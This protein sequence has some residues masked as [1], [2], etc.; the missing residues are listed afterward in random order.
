MRAAYI[1]HYAD[2]LGANRSLLELVKG[3]REGHG[4]TPLVMAPREGDLTIALREADIPVQVFP[5]EPWMTERWY[6]GGPHHR[7]MQYWRE[8]KAAR[9]RLRTNRQLLPAMV[10][11]LRA[12]GVQLVH[13]NSAVAGI[14]PMVAAQAGV[15]LVWHVREMPEQHYGMHLDAGRRGYGD[16]LTKADRVIAISHAVEADVRRYAPKARV[17]VVYNGVLAAH[18]FAELAVRTGERWAVDAPF[19]F[20]MVGLIHPGKHQVEAVE[21]LR[22]LLDRGIEARLVIVGAGREAPVRERIAQLGLSAHVELTGYLAEP[23]DVLFRSHAL[24]MCSRNEA[25]G[26]AT[27]EAMACG[28]SVIGH[29]SGG[30]P[31]LVQHGVSG[32]LYPG[33]ALPLA[34]QMALLAADGNLARRLGEQ[35][36]QDAAARF[37]VERSCA[38]VNAVYTEVLHGR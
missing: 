22:G 21:A 3:L 20:A 36:R 26:R 12:E 10:G 31:E 4:V 1:T 34:E 33:G 24:L 35:A 19:T 38:E 32:L 27:V 37:S 25:M 5:F 18:R 23:F 13:A 15:P 29:A 7:L 28:L 11:A 6:G 9:A 14:A 30:T 17:R 8:E 16:A 2:L